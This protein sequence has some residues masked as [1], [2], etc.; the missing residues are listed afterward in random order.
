MKD[1]LIKNWYYVL[2]AVLA[3]LS[4]TVSL[5]VSI[6]KNKG[7]N[8][9]DS[10]KVSL[11]ENIPFWAVLSENLVS[12]EDKKNNVISLGIA[13]A[14]KILGKKLT[15]EETDYFVAF[16]TE[17]LEKVLSA[18]QKKLV[19]AENPQKSKYRIGG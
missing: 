8:L 18:P 19:K 14:S 4:F 10:V 2:L 7:T 17:Q 11:M 12:G 16:I 15:G 13:L 1:F 9:L 3:V 5:I 6:K